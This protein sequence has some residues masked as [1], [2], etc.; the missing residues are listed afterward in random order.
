MCG[1]NAD[2]K[3]VY[4][5]MTAFRGEDYLWFQISEG[6]FDTFMMAQQRAGAL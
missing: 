2:F 4:D 5:S 3:K 1:Q 6:T